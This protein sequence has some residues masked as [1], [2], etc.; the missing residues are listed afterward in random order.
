MHTAQ[1]DMV[2]LQAQCFQAITTRAQLD[3]NE[4]RRQVR[5]EQQRINVEHCCETFPRND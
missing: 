5:H 4:Q 1:K 2:A 3:E